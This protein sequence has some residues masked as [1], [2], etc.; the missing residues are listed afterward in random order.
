MA[1]SFPAIIFSLNIKRS[2][3]KLCSGVR[4]ALWLKIPP[5]Q[6]NFSGYIVLSANPKNGAV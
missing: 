1:G 3:D 2:L 5:E 6:H 4:L